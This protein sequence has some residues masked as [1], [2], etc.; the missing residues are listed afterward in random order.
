MPG[1]TKSVVVVR[2]QQMETWE[3]PL[4]DVGPRDLLLK[5]EMVGICGSEP[6]KYMGTSVWNPPY[7]LILGHEMVGFVQEIGEEAARR[8]Q[9][10][11][12]D[13]IVV[14]P[15]LSCGWCEFCSTGYYQLCVNRRVYGTSDSCATPPHLFGGYGRHLFVSWGSKVHK[16]RPDVAPEAA[17]LASVIGNGIRWVRTKGQV[18]FLESVVILG[19][20]AQGLASVI[21]AVESGAEPIVMVGL[22]RDRKR[23]ALAAEFGAHHTLVAD[24][25][26]V[27]DAVRDITSGKMASVV[28]ECTGTAP[29]MNLALDLARPLGRVSLPG[30]PHAGQQVP[31]LMEKVVLKE[32]TLK[33]ALGQVVE[34][35]DAVRLINSRR[36]PIEKIATH[37]FPLEEAEK[38]MKLFM[39][40]DPDCIRVALRP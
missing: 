16:I 29:G 31:L 26:D 38:G 7:P 8:Y 30:L 9:V 27:A 21:S 2:P 35:T 28:V 11:L 14:E 23:L 39:S 18:Q 12:G 40:G 5:V 33:G 24:E 4:P 32:L 3:F 20:G 22:A 19:P 6:K 37:V 1:T 36:Y 13:R 34:V 15:Y 10:A 25:V 17:H